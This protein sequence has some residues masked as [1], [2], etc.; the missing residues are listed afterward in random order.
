MVATKARFG[1]AVN[2]TAWNL[3]R[4][5]R[6]ISTSG[7]PATAA[8]VIYRASDVVN[9]GSMMCG[10]GN[11]QITGNALQ[12]YKAFVGELQQSAALV[13]SREIEVA[14]VGDY[15]YYAAYGTSTLSTM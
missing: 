2:S 10:T 1:T 9:D 6:Q 15:E 4:R 12:Q 11:E 13:A 14:I 7:G 5:L 8:S 3:V